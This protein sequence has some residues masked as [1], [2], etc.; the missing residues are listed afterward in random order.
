MALSFPYRVDALGRTATP[1]G[2]ASHAR[3]LLEQF[4]F[5]SP[6]ERVMRPTFGGAVQQLVFSPANDQASAAVQHLIGGGIQQWLST[7]IE[8]QSVDV[9]GDDAAMVITI[10]YLLRATGGDEVA[11]FRVPR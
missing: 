10:R 5:T 6:G 4:L 9:G 7:W 2:A 3:E 1:S 11:E 8:L